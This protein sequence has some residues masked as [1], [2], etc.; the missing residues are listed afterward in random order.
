MDSTGALE[1]EDIP[2]RILVV[3]GGI[4]GLEMA[5]VYE[6]LGSTITI[7]EMLDQLIPPADKD[8]VQHGANDD[9]KNK[10]GSPGRTPE[11]EEKYVVVDENGDACG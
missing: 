11:P 6:G 1:L 4:I 3:G 5:Q 10:D 2:G 9:F 7:V 8:M